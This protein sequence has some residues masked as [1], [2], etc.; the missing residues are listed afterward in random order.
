[1]ARPQWKLVLTGTK[2]RL[3]MARSAAVSPTALPTAQATATAIGETRRAD[4]G[5][6]TAEIG[7][8]TLLS[9]LVNL[10]P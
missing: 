8:A 10:A 3:K 1:M 9:E 4:P 5:P 7:G 6:A 2:N